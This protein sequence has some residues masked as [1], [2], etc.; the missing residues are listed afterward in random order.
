MKTESFLL[1][2]VLAIGAPA[3]LQAEEAEQ[4]FSADYSVSLFGLQVA[5]SS[6]TSTI[7]SD[8]F[9]IEGS[10]SSAGIAQIFDDTKG[11][12]AVSGHFS[13]EAV[14]PQSYL[15]RYTS[16]KKNKKTEITFS[17]GAVAS[18]END[19][20]LKTRKNWVA[21][22][23][24]DLAG[25][26]DPLSA[27]LVKSPSL[28]EVC[29]RTLKIYDGEM[30]ADLALSK[31]SSEALWPDGYEGEAVTCQVR[32]MPVSGY[33]KRDKSLEFLKNKSKILIAFAPLG[34][35]GVYAPVQASV[36]TEIGTIRV[37]AERLEAN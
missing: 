17:E 21:L 14:R 28:E 29:D 24:G 23:E 3:S 33:K 34:T 30:R 5:R 27:T 18:T 12:T 20:P 16:G 11:T 4:I 13:G 10:L 35:T 8:A 1:C 22:A 15:V 2:A 32:F 9:A 7:S 36:S 37:E 25:V 6:F 19:P 26:A 31:V